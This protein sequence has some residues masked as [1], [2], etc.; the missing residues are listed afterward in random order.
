MH[1]LRAAGSSYERM[2]QHLNET[3]IPPAMGAQWQAMAGREII[4]RTQPKQRRK[5]A[6][7]V[8]N[9]S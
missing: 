3:G 8:M 4:Q 5:I 6:S 7:C 9:S 1:R 2:A